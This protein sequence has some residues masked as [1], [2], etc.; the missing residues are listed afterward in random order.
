MGHEFCAEVIEVAPGSEHLREGD[1][2]VSM[3]IAIDSA[4]VHTVG[5]SNLYPGG[6]GEEMIL[7]GMLCTKVPNGLSYQHAALTEPMA[8]GADPGGGRGGSQQVGVREAAAARRRVPAIDMVRVGAVAALLA[9][10]G[11]DDFG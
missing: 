5:Y 3:P 8:V 10:A 2:I 7:S 11:D 9:G 1:L 4:G 6:Y